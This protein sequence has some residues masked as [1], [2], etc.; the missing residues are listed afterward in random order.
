M[1]HETMEYV[2]LCLCSLHGVW[3]IINLTNLDDQ[4]WI[5]TSDIRR[6]NMSRLQ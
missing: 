6:A 1:L 3:F 2:D 5:K 4:T